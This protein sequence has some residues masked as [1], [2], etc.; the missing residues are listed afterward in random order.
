MLS[1]DAPAL[2][3]R[4]RLA[5]S[6]D[7][8]FRNARAIRGIDV[9]GDETFKAKLA[10]GPKHFVVVTLGMLH[11]LNSRSTFRSMALA[12][13]KSRRLKNKDGPP[14]GLFQSDQLF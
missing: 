4:S 3:R 10:G 6:L 9:F 12:M 11:V 1:V 8:A 14:G 13:V 5:I 2:C 7:P